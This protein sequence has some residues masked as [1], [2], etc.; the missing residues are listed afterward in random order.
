MEEIEKWH[1]PKLKLT[2]RVGDRFMFKSE[3]HDVDMSKKVTS[4][5]AASDSLGI[6]ATYIFFDDLMFPVYKFVSWYG[7]GRIKSMNFTPMKKIDKQ[8]FV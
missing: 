3:I 5:Q 7:D 6:Y 4:I 1:I 2:V 8:L